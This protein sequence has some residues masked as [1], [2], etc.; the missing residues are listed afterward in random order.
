MIEFREIPT[1][2]SGGRWIDLA[3]LLAIVPENDWVWSVV[4]F[5][6]VSAVPPLGLAMSEFEERIQASSGG[7]RY[8]WSGLK[9]FAADLEQTYDTLIVGASSEDHIVSSELEAENFEHCWVILRA[10]DSTVW[11]VGINDSSPEFER[12]SSALE[13]FARLIGE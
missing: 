4:E 12:M 11:Q 7:M 8:S 5:C 6:G 1:R 10:L 9:E 3:D 13:E 2:S